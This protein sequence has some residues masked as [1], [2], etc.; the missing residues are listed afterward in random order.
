MKRILILGTNAG[1]ADIIDYLK[2]TGW[3]VH[4]CAYKREGPG[5][6]LAH[7]FHLV[8]TLDVKAVASLAEKIDAQLLYSVSSDSA[9]KTVTKVSE[10][11]GLPHFINSEIIELFDK[12]ELLRQFLN[13]NNICKVAY[14]SFTANTDINTWIHFPCVVK[15]S[16]SQGQRGVQLIENKED[17]ANAIALA[18]KESK[19]GKAIVEEYFYGVEMSSNVVVQ[20]RKLIVNEFTERYVH[21][22]HYFGLPK[23]HAIPVRNVDLVTIS[24]AKQMIE[25][26]VSTLEI[27]NAILYIQMVATSQGPKIIEVAPR[28]DGCHIWR[29][30][31]FAKSYDLRAYAI[32]LLLNKQVIHKEINE[33]AYTLYFNQLPANKN[34][35][36]E[37]FKIKNNKIVFEEYRYK[38]GD[39]IIPINGKLEVVGYY[40]IKE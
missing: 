16:D 27:E 30:I 25:K 19:S 1:Q 26:M 31:S 5:C 24:M 23:G 14:A 2:T 22:K 34:F 20:N 9:I 15:P 28:L 32:D 29:L 40:I 38:N 3:E 18:I 12:K 37:E 35:N 6:N 11:L 10:I 17:F 39:K 33:G 36:R 4:A 7:Y 13:E 21:G 8:D